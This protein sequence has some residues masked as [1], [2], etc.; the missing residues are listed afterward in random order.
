MNTM[1]KLGTLILAFQESNNYNKCMRI[2]NSA[3]LLQTIKA[4][5]INGN[6]ADDLKAYINQVPERQIKS[7]VMQIVDGINFAIGTDYA[8]LLIKQH[9]V[10][11]WRLLS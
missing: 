10:D 1:A 8:A 4:L 2:N 5:I 6:Y 7:D 9:I 3:K 11:R